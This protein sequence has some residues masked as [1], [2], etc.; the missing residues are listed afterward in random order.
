MLNIICVCKVFK[1]ISEL[2]KMSLFIYLFSYLSI[3]LFRL[4][5]ASYTITIKN[6]NLHNIL[7]TTNS[8][9]PQNK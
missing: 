1:V 8:P 6:L 4:K 9:K 7:L 3:Y 5:L 2:R